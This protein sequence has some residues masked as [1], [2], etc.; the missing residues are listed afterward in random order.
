MVFKW[1]IRDLNTEQEAAITAEGNVLLIAC[2][3]SGKTRT[4]TYKLAYEL[5]KIQGSK[6]YV[7]AI[8]YTHRA[9]DEIKER[10]QLLGVNT[11]QLWIGTIHSFCLEWIIK[12]YSLY[13]DDLKKGYTVINSHDSEEIISELCKP[14]TNPRITYYDCDYR[15]TPTKFLITCPDVRK[16]EGVIAILTEYLNLLKQ[17]RQIDFELILSYTFQILTENPKVGYILSNLFAYILVDEYQDTKK[18]QYHIISMIINN[19]VNHLILNMFV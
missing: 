6:K 3:G 11:Q 2:P 13:I 7:I 8:T 5:S 12:P 4:L 16:Q 15:T 10:V 18:I 14:Y 9:A 19:N 17:R 1:N